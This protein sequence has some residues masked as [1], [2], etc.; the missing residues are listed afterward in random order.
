MKRLSFILSLVALAVLLTGCLAAK[1]NVRIQP[2]PIVLTAE[3]LLENDFVISDIKL[4]LRT[5][6][7]SVS[8]YIEAVQV[9]VRDENGDKVFA[10]T[11][12][13]DEKTPIRPGIPID[14]EVP[15]ISLMDLFDFDPDTDLPI[16]VPIDD[17]AYQEALEEEFTKYYNDNWKGKKY[18]LIVRITGDNPTVDKA[19]IQFK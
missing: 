15:V 8:Y 7:F 17:E 18:E 16:D 3:E 10:K 19:E 5:S 12:T 2:N 6:G 13:I 11:K 14:Q 9:E 1:V 4:E